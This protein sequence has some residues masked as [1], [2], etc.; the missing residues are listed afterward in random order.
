MAP[1]A[2]GE[3]CDN[4]TMILVQIKKPVPSEASPSDGPLT[5]LGDVPSALSEKLPDSDG[6]N[7]ETKPAECGSSS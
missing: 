4:M 2:G 5:S 7:A 3:G 1:T 6:V